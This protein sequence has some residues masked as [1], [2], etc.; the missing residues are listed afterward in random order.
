MIFKTVTDILQGKTKQIIQHPNRRNKVNA[1]CKGTLCFLFGKYGN[2]ITEN[3]NESHRKNMP[4]CFGKGTLFFL[5]GT[6]N[7]NADDNH[8]NN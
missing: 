8:E 5:I 2:H 4:Y 3:N 6:I 1:I 7:E